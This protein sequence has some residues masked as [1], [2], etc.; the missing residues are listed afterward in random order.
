LGAENRLK[1]VTKHGATKNN[2]RTPEYSTWNGIKTRCLSKTHKSYK[3]Y[4][5]RGI[6]LCKR[7]EK[8]ENFLADVGKKPSPN[9]SLDRINVNGNYEPENCRW[10]TKKEQAANK[11]L[12]V[13][14]SPVCC[15]NCKTIFNPY[16]KK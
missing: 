5:A 7:W 11:R 15:P 10:A 12:K 2:H 16:E 4:G 13:F 6:T 8:F 1:A 9:H 14:A 3:E